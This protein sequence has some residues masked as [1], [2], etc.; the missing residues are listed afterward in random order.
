MRNT[1]A[2]LVIISLLAVCVVALN[3]VMIAWRKQVHQQTQVVEAVHEANATYSQSVLRQG[4]ELL[5]DQF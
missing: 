3:G 2:A 5:I 1:K 4:S